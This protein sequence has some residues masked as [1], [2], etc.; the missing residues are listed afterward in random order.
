MT[1]YAV[2]TGHHCE[3][4]FGWDCHGLPIEYEIDKRWNIKSSQEREAIGVAEYNRR[5]REIVMTYSAEWE[6]IVGRFG[7]WIDFQN[8]YKTMDTNF[9][10]SVW[11]TFKQIHNK[12][13]VY[14]GSRI[15]P[16]STACNT[17]L[18]NFEAGSN[19][20]DTKDPSVFIT[21]PLVDE[22]ETSM[23]AWTTTPWTLPSNL[24]CAVNPEFVY[25]KIK[26]EEK[27]KVYIVAECRLKETLK[28]ANIKKHTVI[29]KLKG[30]D[31]VGKSYIPLFNYFESFKETNCFTIIAGAFVTKDA[32]TGIVHCAP[33]FGEEDYKV[34]MANG[35]VTS[36]K[37][38]MPMDDDGRFLASV[39]DYAGQYFKDADPLIIKDLKA[40][41]RLVAQGT[42]T[43]SYPF[44]WR[45]ETPLMYRAINTWFI[46]VTDIKDQLLKNNEDPLWVP[47]FVQEKR[48]KNWLADARDWCFSRSRYWGNPIPMWVSDDG[49]EV[50]CVGS[51]QELRELSGC[52]EI[53]DLH[54]EHIDHIQIPSKQGKGMLKR[55][56]EVFD[57]WFESGSMP[58]ASSHYPFSTDEEAFSKKFPGDFIAEGLDQTRGWF[59][60]L[61]VISTAI[62]GCA[63]FKN[64]IV[65]GIVLAEDGTKMS[66][67]KKNYPDPLYIAKEYGADACRLY[68]CNSPVVRAE[69]L[70]FKEVGVKS[71]IRE[72]FLPWF[73]SYRFLIQNISRYEQ[74]F[75]K[76]FVFDP[77]MMTTIK[78][79]NLTDRWMIS[80][81][82]NLIKYVR[83]EME[84][85]KLYQ[86]VKPLLSFLEKLS[87]WYVRLNRPRMKGEEGEIEQ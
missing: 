77:N 33:G 74:T 63:P 42:C 24:A 46:K 72:I 7:R 85:Y 8:D 82:Q 71:V 64:L 61:M 66:K 81:T 41:D 36:G 28:Q 9:M 70:Q 67:S 44:C 47:A 19:Y 78:D 34:C 31:L 6:Q 48:F 16:F 26:D 80:A 84:S 5:C 25:L 17:V 58:F 83:V 27:G 35:L 45:S 69:Q 53:T 76:N 1:R 3:R 62:K 50:I 87:N 23:I 57:C 55:I 10:E 49:E 22:P 29:E 2:M 68:L 14:R 38:V 79:A 56:P 39:T 37:L 86:V 65:N 11:W 51:I 12:G 32:G 30:K 54:R 13:L 4:R 20:K 60:T 15:M 59:Y 18:S 21:F 40:K 73:N 52:G 43:H 75:N